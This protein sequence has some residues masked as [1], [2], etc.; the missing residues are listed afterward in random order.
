VRLKSKDHEDTC[1]KEI[2]LHFQILMNVLHLIGNTI[3]RSYVSS[4]EINKHAYLITI[5]KSLEVR[6]SIQFLHVFHHRFA[7]TTQT[8]FY[9]SNRW[10]LE[11]MEN[12]PCNTQIS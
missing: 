6:F 10:K 3:G 1:L 9:K 11:N 7:N 5:N 2:G 8:L 4:L 12:E